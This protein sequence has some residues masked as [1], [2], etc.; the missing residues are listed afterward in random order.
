MISDLRRAISEYVGIRHRSVFFVERRI[1]EQL[2]FLVDSLSDFET[3]FIDDILL[4]TNL[5]V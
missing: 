3:E 5:A 1:G 4:C 2:P